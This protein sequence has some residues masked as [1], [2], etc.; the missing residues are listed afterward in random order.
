LATTAFAN[1][2]GGLVLV[3]NLPAAGNRPLTASSVF[4][5]TY[6]NYRIVL[7][8]YGSNS[9]DEW[10][11]RFLN[12]SNAEITSTDYTRYGLG[13]VTSGAL[14]N[15]YAA[16]SNR[17]TIGTLASV[18]TQFASATIDVFNP[19]TASRTTAH[20]K[21]FSVTTGENLDCT[22]QL[23]LT[24]ALSGFVIYGVAGNV[25]GSCKVYGYRNS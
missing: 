14:T 23:S 15:A 21:S 5:S 6:L 17:L 11:L 4:N 9:S 25:F 7:N 20:F 3:A 16:S 12:A 1:T 24:D 22:M 18:S 8:M 10:Y 19:N 13:V 2:A